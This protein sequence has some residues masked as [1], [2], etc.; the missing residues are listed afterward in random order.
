MTETCSQICTLSAA[1]A[2]RK[3][4]SA[5]RPLL[6]AQVE[7]DEGEIVVFGPMLAAG[8]ADN[9]GRLRTGDLGR[10]DEEGFLWVEGRRDDLIVTGGENVRPEDVEEILESHPAVAE[11]A[12]VGRPDPEWG[13]AVVAVVVAAP[14]HSPDPGE[15]RELCRAR[16]APFKV[17]KSVELAE[18]LPRTGSG[19]LQRRLLR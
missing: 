9:D 10:L 1:D 11:A 17:P 3:R 6:G 18:S 14:G 8:A 5:G 19:K 16:L 12:V 7:I 15:L 13:S 2:S 4:G